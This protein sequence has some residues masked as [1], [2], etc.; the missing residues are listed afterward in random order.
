MADHA[1]ASIAELSGQAATMI[2]YGN[3]DVETLCCLNDFAPGLAVDRD[4]ISNTLGSR[5]PFWIPGN[6]YGFIWIR[7]RRRRNVV[8]HRLDLIGEPSAIDK[9]RRVDDDGKHAIGR[10]SR[11][12]AFRPHRAAAG[13]RPAEDLADEGECVAFVLAEG[14]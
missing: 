14:H 8:G 1:H 2:W 11:T 3:R 4:A 10:S 5:L 9:P 13:N 7:R 12:L 6:K